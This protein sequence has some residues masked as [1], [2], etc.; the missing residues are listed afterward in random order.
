M[1]QNREANPE[2]KI[3]SIY[4]AKAM[5]PRVEVTYG[6]LQREAMTRGRG[7]QGTMESDSIWGSVVIQGRGQERGG[8]SREN[9]GT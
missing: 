2:A 5:W 8:T 7:N 4:L 9:P 6:E 1:S 3:Q